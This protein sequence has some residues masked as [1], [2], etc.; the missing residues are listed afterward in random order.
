MIALRIKESKGERKSKRQINATRATVEI[1]F[2]FA[3]LHI[4]SQASA[5]K[6]S[7]KL[8]FCS[9]LSWSESRKS[10]FGRCSLTNIKTES[11]IIQTRT[12]FFFRYRKSN[13]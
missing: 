13:E 5:K 2:I 10:L 7:K 11:K 9:I 4:Q 8:I 12:E 3:S 1:I 6:R